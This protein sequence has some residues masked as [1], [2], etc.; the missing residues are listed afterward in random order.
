[1]KA[2]YK[3]HFDCGRNGDLYGLFIE[4]KEKVES[5]MESGEVVYFGEVL[6]KHSEIM[7][8]IEEADLTFVTDDEKVLAVVEHYGLEHGFNPFDYQTASEEDL[9]DIENPEEDV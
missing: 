7:G 3:F 2:L 8:P 1:M 9:E 4:E 6:G 5:L